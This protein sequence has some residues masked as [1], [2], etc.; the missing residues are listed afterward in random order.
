A[1]AE[2]GARRY[3]FLG[4]ADFDESYNSASFEAREIIAE[5]QE[6]VRDNPAQEAKALIL[7]QIASQR[8]D[9]LAA[10]EKLM[11]AGDKDHALQIIRAGEGE[12]LMQ[13]FRNKLAL[14]QQEE[15]LLDAE[16]RKTLEESRQRF[17]WLLAAGTSAAII[18]GGMLA[19]LFT[20]GIS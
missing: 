17:D 19:F 10:V 6:L 20:R 15:A 7:G 11:R 13:E 14:F 2:T 18:L 16:R 3:V 9:D 4:K 1:D 12:R 8:M 5:L